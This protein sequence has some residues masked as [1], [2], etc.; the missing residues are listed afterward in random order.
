MEKILITTK[1]EFI[2][3]FI[4][5]IFKPHT[6]GDILNYSLSFHKNTWELTLILIDIWLEKFF[7]ES[8]S[9]L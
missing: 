6:Y 8:L 1:L 7:L 5:K 2:Y 9:G 3:L 4:Q